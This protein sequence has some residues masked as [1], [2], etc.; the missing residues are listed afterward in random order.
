MRELEIGGEYWG[1][2]PGYSIGDIKMEGM[3]RK[4]RGMEDRLK[5]I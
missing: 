2:H 1:I 3:N 4:M 5:D